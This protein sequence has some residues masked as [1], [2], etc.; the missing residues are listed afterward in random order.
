MPLPSS[1]L[2]YTIRISTS[3]I[4]LCGA[5]TMNAQLLNPFTID[6]PDSVSST[7]STAE[8]STL[9]FNHGR[10][11]LSGQYL[12]VGR[13]DGYITLWDIE[14]RSVLRLLSGHVRAVTG[15]AW[16]SNN[17]YLASCGGDWNVVIWDLKANDQSGGGAVMRNTPGGS[18]GGGEEGKVAF[19]SERKRTLRFDCA[20]TSVQFAPQSSRRLVVVLA[21]QE[22]FLVD[23]QERVRIRR[24]RGKDAQIEVE[25]VK[26]APTRIP[27]ISA[28]RTTSEERDDGETTTTAGITAARFTPDSR[29]IV[30][31]TSKGVL[32]I[33][34]AH[35]GELVDEQKVLGTTSGVKELA[36]DSAGRYLVVNCNDR[37]LRVLSVST[38][39]SSSL[40]LTLLHRIQDMI[41]RTAWNNIGFSPSSDYIFA[42]AAHKASHNIYI[43]DRTSSTLSKILEGPKDWSIGVDWHPARPM[44]ASVSNTGAIYVWFTPT[45]EIWSAYAPGFEELEEN[46]EYEEREDEFDFIDGKGDKD[47]RRM[48]EEEAALVRI[49]RHSE[50]MG[51]E[52][53]GNGVDARSVWD[54]LEA[55]EE[56]RRGVRARALDMVLRRCGELSEDSGWIAT[57]EGEQERRL[58]FELLDD[59]DSDTFVIPPRLEIDYSDFHDDHF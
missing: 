47:K 51:V 17:R 7:L 20:V 13:S 21:S 23:L 37:A 32:L 49:G 38:S 29:F 4:R 52:R 6:I 11:T 26:H 44:L 42:G 39:R 35:S 16:S 56:E 54:L 34:D 57:G 59:D 48:E 46:Q 27:L 30:A 50:R 53:R 43:W 2:S 45:E 5:P 58:K 33:F 8:C 15:L 9:L 31:G 14:T 40:S 19:A 28:R 10:S 36:F 24:R 22:A 18:G 55:A 25:D 3:L 41:Q 12:A 1:F